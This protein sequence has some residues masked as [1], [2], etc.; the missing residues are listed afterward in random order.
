MKRSAVGR[1]SRKGVRGRPM[2]VCRAVLAVVVIGWSLA[3]A[4]AWAYT[5]P[6]SNVL[7]IQ[8]GGASL[9]AIPSSCFDSWPS[10]YGVSTYL[11]GANQ[12]W[13]SY[14]KANVSIL[15]ASDLGFNSGNTYNGGADPCTDY[16]GDWDTWKNDYSK[17]GTAYVWILAGVS[18]TVPEGLTVEFGSG[19]WLFVQGTLNVNG[20]STKPAIIKGTQ[21]HGITML[22]T[23]SGQFSHCKFTG[24]SGSTDALAHAALNIVGAS[25][26]IDSCEFSNNDAYYG[27]AI[28]ISGASPTIKNSTIKN[29]KAST[30]AGIYIASGSPVIKGTEITGNTDAINGGGLY[31][32]G[33][34]TP[35]LAQD[36]IGQNE[37]IGGGGM[38]INGAS[39]IV[40][41]TI[42]VNNSGSLAGGGILF[43]GTNTAKVINSVVARNDSVQGGGLYVNSNQSAPEI[44]NSIVWGNE[45]S[46]TG[47][48]GPQVHLD[49]SSVTATW[50][51]S[52]VE[53]GLSDFAGNT[54]SVT[55]TNNLDIDPLFK[56]P[57]ADAGSGG[58]GSSADWSLQPD[59]LAVNAGQNSAF[60]NNSAVQDS[61]GNSID[62]AGATRIFSGNAYLIDIGAY[63]IANN[64]PTLVGGTTTTNV[65]V[66][67]SDDPVLEALCAD[68]TDNDV[69]PSGT[70]SELV[71]WVTAIPAD[72][73]GQ[74]KQYDSGSPGNVIIS[75]DTAV[76]DSSGRVYFVP[77]NR[78]SS[79]TA[80][81]TCVARDVISVGGSEDAD[82]SMSSR[83]AQTFHFQ[84]SASNDAPTYTSAPST[85]AFLNQ[86]FDYTV[87]VTDADEDDTADTL[88][89]SALTLPSWLTFQDTDTTDG[90]AEVSGTPTVAGTY[91]VTL[92]VRDSHGG[93]TDQSFDLTVQAGPAQPDVDAGNDASAAPGDDVKLSGTGPSG[94]SYTYAWTITDSNGATVTTLQGTDVLW[95]PA[96]EGSYTATLEVTDSGGA[97]MGTDSVTISVAAG[98]TQ[99]PADQRIDPTSQQSQDIADIGSSTWDAKSTADQ[100][101]SLNGLAQ[102]KLTSAQR[103]AVLS[104]A[105]DLLQQAASGQVSLT[106]D[107][108]NSLLGALDN[109]AIDGAN[110]SLTASQTNSIVASLS[111]VL[112]AAGGSVTQLQ[113][114]K[115]AETLNTLLTQVGTDNLSSSQVDSV[116]QL[117]RKISLS[118]MGA[119]LSMTATGGDG[120]QIAT[121]PVDLTLGTPVTLGDPNPGGFQVTLS[122]AT[123]AEIR[124][125]TGLTDVRLGA[126]AN[127]ASNGHG[128]LATLEIMDA[129]GNVISSLILD[130]PIQ[131]T[132]PV[133]DT[134]KKTPASV[135][136]DPA[137]TTTAV[138][139]SDTAVTFDTNGFGRY[140]LVDDGLAD[141][142]SEN[143][144]GDKAKN[145]AGGSSGCFSGSVL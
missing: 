122:A 132:V 77:A 141:P 58:T 52:V 84:V 21:W 109:L 123:L 121:A 64:P 88:T 46:G 126:V 13:S 59:S 36:V 14:T 91:P 32:T 99:V 87:R 4:P 94:S 38:Y 67:E 60:P 5:P 12:T 33:G 41:N 128:Y 75:G 115:S 127:K 139:G 34:G 105:Q 97:S 104:G 73:H 106:A 20:S 68:R 44:R 78:S 143:S 130:Q 9:P 25:V 129:S 10:H 107:Q 54:G 145:T 74:I 56:A 53:G 116:D 28:Y 92:R 42:V 29:N 16:Q 6:S 110:T 50:D 133:T 93:F 76:D 23:A 125:K 108:I 86:Q 43:D 39:P 35:V 66:D 103:D 18:L 137:I 112:D 48:D 124:Q 30:G 82:L 55:Y 118:A 134:T 120:V 15:S 17:P 70:T 135:S 49:T 79:Y 98:F 11:I 61:G 31:I 131:V 71:S 142:P 101:S 95:T 24:S 144:T 1:V 37:A 100:V 85:Q 90:K 117:S 83:D 62:Y 45:V 47:A 27:G 40:A 81:V 72:G 3:G 63:E 96:S 22:G 2:A 57:S 65:S 119:G 69:H 26:T 89:I 140:V 111:K 80:D 102:L 114:L 7:D 138:S 51:H 19:T 113:A 136:T 8:I